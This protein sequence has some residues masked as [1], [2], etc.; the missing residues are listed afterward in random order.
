MLHR[1]L[2]SQGFAL[3]TITSDK[4][5]DVL[6]MVEY[7]GITHPIVSDTADPVTG[8]VFE[9][10]HA[11]DGKHYLIRGDGTILAAFSKLGVSLP[12]LRRE[13][14]KHGIG[15]ATTG[16]APAARASAAVAGEARAPVVWKA[17]ARP[18]AAA[19]G[20]K[21]SVTLSATIDPGWRV[22]AIT[23]T[24]GGPTP[25]AIGLAERQPFTLAGAVKAPAAIV[26]FDP[27]FGMDVATHEDRAEFVLPVTVAAGAKAGRQTL[28]VQAHYQ[29]CNANIC[30]PPQTEAVRVVVTVTAG[31]MPRL[32]DRLVSRER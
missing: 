32:P 1:E 24:G 4:A 8:K 18:A 23:Q 28:T 20:G 13:L 19:P 5:A 26:K 29:T 9:K 6:K 25:L 2:K 7:N 27:N 10:Y 15:S 31:R 14:A 16:P 12:I 21:L 3:L 17:S 30:L 22:Y 11:Y